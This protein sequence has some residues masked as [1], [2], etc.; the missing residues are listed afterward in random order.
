MID[1][2]IAGPFNCV[3]QGAPRQAWVAQC[4]GT[5]ARTALKLLARP[6]WGS[7]W[8]GGFRQH[9]EKFNCNWMGGCK[10][11]QLNFE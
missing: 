9:I 3:A 7:W 10:N 11:D 2:D 8:T 5:A 6:V 1:L 4:D